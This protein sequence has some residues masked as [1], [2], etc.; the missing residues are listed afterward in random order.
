MLLYISVDTSTPSL[1]KPYPASTA[2]S[3]VLYPKGYVVQHRANEPRFPKK[4]ASTL[5]AGQTTARQDL[6]L[7]HE[8]LMFNIHFHPGALY[9]FLDIPMIE[10]LHTDIDAELVL[11]QEVHILN[12]QLANTASYDEMVKIVETYLSKKV[13]AIKEDIR[14]IDKIGKL[15]ADNPTFFS[16]DKLARQA[17]FSVSQ[18]ERIFYQQI[19]V[20]PKLFARISRFRKAF[21][22][23][24][25]NPNLDWLQIAY[26]L[27][28]TDYQHLVK[29]FKQF[30]GNTPNTL[31]QENAHSPER[32]LNL[33][34]RNTN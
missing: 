10:F 19:G 34:Q 14:P 32:L 29:D 22:M 11:G 7:S 23:K 13:R 17:C 25:Q 6:Q 21:D 5:I 28:Y 18:F 33:V 27:G 30:A 9:K 20:T 4:L 2:H 26:G 1:L 16:L 31:I 8:F 12:E 3:I 15:I 24:E